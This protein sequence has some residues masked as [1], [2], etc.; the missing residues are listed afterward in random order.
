MKSSE[1]DPFV[2]FY[3]VTTL[4]SSKDKENLMVDG[5]IWKKELDCFVHAQQDSTLE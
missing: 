2:G 5:I 1:F 4:K 3:K